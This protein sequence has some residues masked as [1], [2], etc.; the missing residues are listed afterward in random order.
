MP[1]HRGSFAD[2]LDAAKMARRAYDDHQAGHIK[3]HAVR[4]V[5]LVQHTHGHSLAGDHEEP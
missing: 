3:E 2:G 1:R 5:V 4:R